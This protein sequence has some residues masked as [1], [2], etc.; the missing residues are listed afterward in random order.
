M[1]EELK[2]VNCGCGGEAKKGRKPLSLKQ[3]RS[4]RVHVYFNND[5]LNHLYE[6]ADYGN[7][8]LSMTLNLCFQRYFEEWKYMSEIE[9]R[10]L[11]TKNL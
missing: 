6:V 3:R 2:P 10:K 4:C 5:D 7:A 1:G 11:W 9:R 8:S